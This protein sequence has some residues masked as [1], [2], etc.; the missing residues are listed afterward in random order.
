M[1]NKILQIVDVPTW[2]IEKLSKPIREYNN[3][4]NWNV[5]Y[6]HPKDLENGKVDLNKIKDEIIKADIVDIQYWRLASQLLELIPELKA[7]KI[8]LTHHNEKNLLSY[9]WSDI[10]VH[11]AKTKYS[12]DVLEEKYPNATIEYIPNTFDFNEF[13]YVEN[14][15]YDKKIVGYVGRIVPWKGF[16]EI[17]MACKE[18]GYELMI[19]GKQDKADYWQEVQNELGEEYLLKGIDW[20]FFNCPDE[21]RA[22]FYENISV[23]VGNSGDKHEVGPL[24][25]IEAMASGIPVVSSPA[26]IMADIGKHRENAMIF[27][28]GNYEEMKNFIR[29]VIENKEL[30]KSLRE[31][32]WQTIK[33]YNHE[34]MAEAYNKIYF[35]LLSEKD[36]VSVVVPFTIERERNVIEILKAL[37]NQTYKDI[38]F[39]GILDEESASLESL[40]E[41][42]KALNLNFP[43]RFFITDKYGYN[44]ALSRNI[45]VIMSNGNYIMLNDSRMLPAP[46]AIEKFVEVLEKSKSKTWVF[47]DKGTEKKT[48]VENFSMIN[49]GNLIKT[50]MFNER[51]CEYGGMSQ[52]LRERFASNGFEFVYVPEAKATQLSKSG[53]SYRRDSII[54]MKNLLNKL[55]L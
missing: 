55:G 44:L 4:F 3:H 18:L 29:E 49:R 9:D 24:G 15:D 2:A 27:P 41:E 25:V 16:K 19:M 12:Y 51:V 42:V 21:E 23:Y 32:G 8:V 20:S 36:V 28:Y 34:Q 22:S 33:S 54:R 14:Y 53:L 31:K 50:G 46:D 1:G 10:D 13:K 30:R 37:N 7:K 35:K 47:G 45:G 17:A 5:L 52:E 43:Y 38:E 6:I 40:D 39:I 26:G 48:F 11:I